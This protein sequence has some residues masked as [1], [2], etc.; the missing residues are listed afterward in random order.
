MN[1]FDASTPA[2]LIFL[3]PGQ[4]SVDPLAIQRASQVH[5]ATGPV[6]EV[7]YAVLGQPR[8]N[9]YF[10]ADGAPID[11]NRDVQLV[12]FLA[13][14]MYLAALAAE[15]VTGADSVGLSLGEYSHLVHIGA[16]GLEDALRLVDERGRLYDEAPPGVMV[17]VL[18]VD[19]DTVAEAVARARSLGEIVISNYNAPT[20][21]VI[22]GSQAAVAW[23][24]A[25]LEDESAAHTTMIEARVP[26]HSPL[27]TPVAAAFGPVLA[28]APW[29]PPVRAYRPNIT[30]GVVRNAT[31]EVFVESLTR[32][33]SEPVR[34]HTSVEGLVDAHADARFLEVGPGR[35]LRNMFARTWKQR[36][37]GHVDGIDHGSAHSHFAATLERLRA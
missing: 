16:L 29:G 10:A 14:Q 5:P 22:A 7:A 6:R 1:P 8:A 26:M 27:M 32:H 25:V 17:T 23:A 34:W 2:P 15:G 37:L 28:R 33:V 30:G 13:T 19:H 36:S 20:Q 9:R 18:A 31:P 35:V 4:S 24:A 12:V 3:F 21:H 11:T